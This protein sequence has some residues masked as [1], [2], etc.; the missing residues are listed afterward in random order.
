MNTVQ[1]IQ[2]HRPLVLIITLLGSLAVKEVLELK[3]SKITLARPLTLDRGP[4]VT[5]K[6]KCLTLRI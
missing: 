2:A 4:V 1:T 3:T 6:M 5:R